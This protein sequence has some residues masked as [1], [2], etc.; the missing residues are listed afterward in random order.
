MFSRRYPYSLREGVVSGETKNP[1]YLSQA[2]RKMGHKVLVISDSIY[3]APS[4]FS[5]NGVEVIN[6]GKMPLKG[7]AYYFAANIAELKKFINL[8]YDDFDMINAHFGISGIITLKKLGVLHIPII[9]TAHG[10]VLPEA[11]ANTESNLFYNIVVRLNGEIQQRIDY[12]TWFNSDKVIS[13]G[14]F[15]LMEMIELHKLPRE[16]VVVIP[17]GVDT[18]FYRPDKK[19]GEKIRDLLKL[20]DKKVVLFVGRLTAKKGLQYLIEASRLIIK[21]LPDVFFLVVGGN[22]RFADYEFTI[23]KKIHEL[24]MEDR[25]LIVK[26]VPELDMPSYYNCAD[27]CVFPSIR[28]EPFP[29]VVLEAMACG[30]PIVASDVGGIPEQLG[31]RDSLVPEKNLKILAKKIIELLEND[32]LSNALSKRNRKRAKEFD[33]S[34]VAREYLK[35]YYEVI[36]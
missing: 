20:N 10:T 9:T 26:N 27:I 5:F 11:R 4:N 31:Y 3:K 34:K 21:R 15:Q 17:N 8:D 16:K 23:R 7:I 1:F 13:V 2:L 32:E 18:A 12:F 35:V 19:A 29:T 30:K 25:F 14:K 36:R 28:Y 6:I 24:H 22:D 33:W